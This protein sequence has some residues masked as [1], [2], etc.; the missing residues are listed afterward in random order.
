MRAGVVWAACLAL[1]ICG[2]EQAGAKARHHATHKHLPVQV[3]HEVH[4]APTS[5]PSPPKVVLQSGHAGA[6]TAR[7]W[8][9]DSRQVVTGGDDGQLI[10]WD[11]EGRM[12]DRVRLPPTDNLGP[13]ERLAVWPDGRGV[14]AY[15]PQYT[16]SE[17]HMSRT[18]VSFGWTFGQDVATMLGRAPSLPRLR[19]MEPVERSIEI[20]KALE[21]PLPSPDRSRLL[22]DQDRVPTI[23]PAQGAGPAVALIGQAGLSDFALSFLAGNESEAALEG[24][25]KPAELAA[26][27]D[28]AM[29]AIAGA[30]GARDVAWTLAPDQ[31]LA[32]W[33]DFQTSVNTRANSLTE[34]SETTVSGYV[35]L[36]DLERGAYLD[37]FATEPFYDSIQWLG[38]RAFMVSSKNYAERPMFV[39]VGATKAKGSSPPLCFAAAIGRDGA[40][41]G[42]GTANCEPTGCYPSADAPE[43]QGP[44]KA[45]E[46]RCA[47]ELAKYPAQGLWVVGADET[48]RPLDTTP[49]APAARPEIITWMEVGRDPDNWTARFRGLLVSAD[50]TRIAASFRQG[51]REETGLWDV[52]NGRLLARIPDHAPTM[53]ALRG[54]LLLTFVDGV[55]E[56]WDTTTGR[57]VRGFGADGRL[58]QQLDVSPD[59]RTLV[60]QDAAG[61]AQRYSAATGEAVGRPVSLPPGQPFSFGDRPL[62]WSLAGKGAVNVYGMESGTRLFSLYNLPGAHFF[63]AD[64]SGRYDSD[65]PPDSRALRWRVS[66][67]RLQSLAPQT[68][69]RDY[70]QPRLMQQLIACAGSVASRC[71]TPFAPVRAL[72]ELNHVLPVTRIV[73]VSADPGGQ[74]ATVVAEAAEGL[75]DGAPAG[76][77]RSGIYDLRLF[78]NG[79]LVAQ[80][81]GG[82]QNAG[83]LDAWRKANVLVP[84]APGQPV[85]RTFHVA[86]PTGGDQAAVF[87]AYAFN[88]DRVKGETARLELAAAKGPARPRHAYVI[89][90]GVDAAAEPSWKLRFAAADARALAK[91]L[92]TIPGYQVTTIALVSTAEDAA[93]TKDNLRAVLRVLATGDADARGRLAAAG[94][95]ASGLREA[96]PDDLVILSFS[97]HGWT[98]RAG[99]FYLVPAGGRRL[100][101]T[102]DPDPQTLI[103]GVELTDWLRPIDAGEA[104]L[105]IDACHSAAS[106]EAGGFK[107]GPM[108]DP[109]LGQLAYDRGIRILAA[110][111]ADDVAQEDAGLGQGLLTYALTHDGLGSGSAADLDQDGS[112]SLDEWLR[113]GAQRLPLLSQERM[114]L[115]PAGA[116]GIVVDDEDAAAQQPSLFDYTG[117]ASPVRLRAGPSSSASAG[118]TARTG[119]AE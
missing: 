78:R 87:S 97:G 81:P 57:K 101:G 45:D 10:L 32:A 66:D 112:V 42:A 111:Q 88:T 76:R 108:G 99:M 92:A 58:Y 117:H 62:Y 114:A 19:H 35:R 17:H 40:V 106:V 65:L 64:P 22:G 9:P 25:A 47:K 7:A 113:Y 70:Y 13:V 89:A 30:E 36:F 31:R 11:L 82:V 77:Q 14:V 63:V 119:G 27:T 20:D 71:R 49:F 73:S 109:G 79:Q 51:S 86:L 104:A 59:G 67:G 75:D 90:V 68:F 74:T 24:Y 15:A 69:M 55:V 85:R 29:T 50:G 18:E 16:G 107:P 38:P 102:E 21:T 95:A 100:A 94:V 44:T 46:A 80:A 8:T 1:A 93:A 83:E 3:V 116:S 103:S 84:E 28:R 91:S 110:A 41:A 4:A 33:I 61:Q 56:G 37:S 12:I 115:R 43:G 53:F 34:T 52:A 60:L 98:D 5:E 105:I 26:A 2:A 39:D 96:T 118:P 23:R 72:N 54:A 48:R 6:V